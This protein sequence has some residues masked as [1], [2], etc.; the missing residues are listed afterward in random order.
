VTITLTNISGEEQTTANAYKANLD[1]YTESGWQDPRGW[2]DGVPKPITDDLWTFEPG[3]KYEWN[4]EM[5]EEGIVE[6][7]YHDED[8]G[9]VTCPG[10]PAGRYRFATSAPEQG[11]V[12]IAFD[13][14]E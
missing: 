9:L 1:V 6:A 11:D 12:A 7:D 13:L 2:E 10:L 14:I 3:E 4:I 5:A 8:D